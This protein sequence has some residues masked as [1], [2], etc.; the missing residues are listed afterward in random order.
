MRR[1]GQ[2][3]WRKKKKKTQVFFTSL[4]NKNTNT[5]TNKGT[6]SIPIQG[7]RLGKKEEE[8]FNISTYK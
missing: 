8:D 4:Q 2:F 7:I 5:P 6:Q 1:T 3:A